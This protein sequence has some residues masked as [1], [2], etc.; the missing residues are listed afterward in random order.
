ME[1]S[2][3]DILK[4]IVT[5]KK[6]F[7][8]QTGLDFIGNYIKE[9]CEESHAEKLIQYFADP[10][11]L[12]EQFVSQIPLYYDSSKLWW[13]W[14]FKDYKWKILDE[15]DILNFIKNSSNANIIKPNTRTEIL[16]A[17]KQISRENKPLDIKKT[18][19][20]FKDEIV[21]I[22]TG[23]R[24]KASP[25]YFV[26]N[27]IPHKLGRCED[28]PFMDKM[29]KEWVGEDYV[30]TLYEIIAYCLIPD[31]P[32]HRIFCLIGSGLNGKSK[33]LELLRN[34][35]GLENTCTTEIDTL[36]SSR[37]EITKLHKKLVCQ[38]G[39]TD[40]A[41]IK[42]TA[43]LKKLS[44]GDLIGFEYKNKTPFEDLNYA[45]IIISTNNLPSTTDKTI[46]F[47]RRWL[48]IDFF[49]QFSEKRDIIEEIPKG[50]YNNLAL[51]VIGILMDLLSKR[52]FSNEGS[53]EDRVKKYEERSNPF[54]K[55]WGEMIIEDCNSNITLSNFKKSLNEWCKENKFREMSDQTIKKFMKERG[56]EQGKFYIDWFENDQSIKKQV[57]GWMGIKFK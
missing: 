52:E 44:G 25:E 23:E 15:T 30:K 28:T 40:F 34:F 56:I 36:I 20:Q 16:N 14:D 5:N 49:N 21:D 43:T 45:K 53:I 47:Y 24:F 48:I 29:F 7:E 4:R 57:R 18:W 3:L 39:E 54:D 38:M 6:S 46:G 17:L 27:P 11:H 8:E 35:V 10:L 26:T 9:N 1:E 19:I 2:D 42:K 55:F 31:Y 50:E 22:E 51:K 33:F 41:E 13:I 32:I 12:A 37:F